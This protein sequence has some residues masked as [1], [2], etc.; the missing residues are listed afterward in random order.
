LPNLPECKKLDPL[1]CSLL[2]TLLTDYVIQPNKGAVVVNEILRVANYEL[3]RE[4]NRLPLNGETNQLLT[5]TVNSPL[6]TEMG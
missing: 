6:F 3:A 1:D 5:K 4:R 2:A